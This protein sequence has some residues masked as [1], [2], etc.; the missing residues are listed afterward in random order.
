MPLP[1]LTRGFA[2]GP[3]PKAGCNEFTVGYDRIAAALGID[4]QLELADMLNI[5]QSSI[6][7]AKRRGVIPGEWAMKLFKNHRL[8]PRW[9]YDGLPPVFLSDQAHG[10]LADG[11]GEEGSFLLKYP[12][13]A[14]MAVRMDDASMEPSIRREAF[15]GVNVLEKDII[16][17]Q[18]H[19]LVLP[20]EGISVR[21]IRPDLDAGL[22]ILTADNPSIPAQRMPLD[23]ARRCIRGRVVW[24]MSPA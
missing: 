14:L 18:L 22:A 12:E 8:N 1:P 19:C 7:D 3:A 10:L 17:G 4:T 16:A 21:R 2:S 23:E 15:V 24:I 6:S 20:V 13:G 11:G 5:R 9:I